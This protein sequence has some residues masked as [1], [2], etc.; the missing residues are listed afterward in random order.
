MD[1][2]DTERSECCIVENLINPADWHSYFYYLKYSRRLAFGKKEHYG[3]LLIINVLSF[4]VTCIPQERNGQLLRRAIPAAQ[5]EHARCLVVVNEKDKTK[6]PGNLRRGVNK[7]GL[8]NM[9]E[10]TYTHKQVYRRKC[11]SRWCL[12]QRYKQNTIDHI[13]QRYIH[14]KYGEIK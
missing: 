10:K 13:F 3:Y 12:F 4:H 11:R 9:Y 5:N 7:F 6:M 2:K 1:R 8:L 14:E